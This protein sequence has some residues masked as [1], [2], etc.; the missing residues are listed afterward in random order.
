[1]IRSD[2][3]MWTPS[4]GACCISF[5]GCSGRCRM[6]TVWVIFSTAKARPGLRLLV[7]LPP[8]WGVHSPAYLT[9]ALICLC[10]PR[11]C[12]PASGPQCSLLSNLTSA[13][14]EVLHLQLPVV[15]LSRGL[16]S[17]M[18]GPVRPVDNERVRPCPLSAIASAGLGPH[19]LLPCEVCPLVHRTLTCF[20]RQRTEN[21]SCTLMETDC[22]L[23][24]AIR[25]PGDAP[26]LREE[27]AEFC[28]SRKIPTGQAP[29][30][31]V[32]PLRTVTKLFCQ[33]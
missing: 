21:M 5:G 11:T 1:M 13:P 3:F 4:V 10:F 32:S 9:D 26:S 24:T 30:F 29:N 23:K 14:G 28:G 6:Y 31:G 27:G 33:H 22:M 7:D 25:Q 2:H 19:A 16:E 20:A 18:E 8:F 15:Y 12:S 17:C